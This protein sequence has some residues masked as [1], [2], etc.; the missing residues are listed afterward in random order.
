V[1]NAVSGEVIKKIVTRS[2]A[3]NTIISLDGEHAYLAG[4]HSPQS[5]A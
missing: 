1:V 2:G 3:H 4:L 5:C